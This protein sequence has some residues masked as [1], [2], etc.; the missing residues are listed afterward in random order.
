[1]ASAAAL[2][3]FGLIADASIIPADPTAARKREH[4]APAREFQPIPARWKVIR[5]SKGKPCPQHFTG[6]SPVLPSPLYGRLAAASAPGVYLPGCR[7]F[8]LPAR[9][10]AFFR[11]V[12]PVR[13]QGFRLGGLIAGMVLLY[14]AIY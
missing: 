1:M 14:E 2:F 6:R 8:K 7:V 9:K 4:G 12:R 11:S 5:I 10:M 13:E 3:C